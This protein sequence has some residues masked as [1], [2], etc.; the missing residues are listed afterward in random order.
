MFTHLHVHTEYSLLDGLCRIAPLVERA[1]EMGMRSLAITDHGSLYG[2]V[3]FYLQARER[4]VKPIIGSEFYVAGGSRFSRTAADKEPYHLVLLAKNKTGYQN[5]LKLSSKSHI[6]G[7]YYKPRVDRELLM[8]HSSG[9]VALSGCLRGEIARLVADGREKEARKSAEW[10]GDLFGADYYLEIQRHPIP[11]MERINNGLL[12][13]SRELNLPLV[14][15]NDVHYIDRQDARWQDLLLCI[16]T[17]SSVKDERRLKMSADSF[18]L[19][20]PEEMAELFNDV[21]EALSNTERIAQ[22]CNLELEFGQLHLPEVELPADKTG[23]AYL[24]ELCRDGLT[25]RYGGA[26]PT[27]VRERLEYELEVVRQTSFAHY[28]LVVWDIVFF[29]RKR[30]ISCG[31][32]G[33]AA[34]SI[35]LYCL[36]VTDVDPLKHKL[37]FERFLNVERKEMP[38]IDLD[39]QDDRRDEIIS[40]VAQKYGHDRVAQIITFGT[41]GAKAALRDVGR[42]LGMPYSQVDQVA[43]LIPFGV[44]ITLQKALDETEEFR[45]IYGNDPIVHELVDSAM[46]LEGI[47]RHAS[48]HAAGVVISKEPL[49]EYVPLQQVSRGEAKGMAMTQFG[50]GDI[51]KVG[52]L[53][54][55]LLG[56]INLTTLCTARQLVEKTRGIQLDLS[57]LP[58]DDRKTFDLLSSG[59]THGVFQLDGAGMRRY[60]KELKPSNFSDLAAMVALYR[61]GPKDHIPAFIRAKHGLEPIHYPHPALAGI[62]EETYGVIVYQDQVLFIVQTFAGYSLGQADIVRKAMGK[63]IPDIMRKE[64]LRFMEGAKRKGFSEKVAEDV[65]NLIEPFAG[66]A[67]NKAHSVSYAMIAYQTAYLKANYPVEYMTALL[68]SASG[69]TD[70]VAT[71]VADCQR[72]GLKVLPPDVNLSD[73][74][75]GVENQEEPA[76]R[77]G[78]ADIKNIG[79]QAIAPIISAVKAGGPF[80][81]L[82]DFCRRC[83][84]RG[85]NKRVLESLVKAGAMDRLGGRAALLQCVDR[86]L[87]VSHREQDLREK[88]QSTMFD[89]FG[90][91]T[92]TPVAEIE[93]PK[94]ECTLRDK[95]TWEKELLGVYLSEHPFHEAARQLASSTT[96]LCGQIDSEMVGQTVTVAGVLVTPRVGQ[97]K[98]R[99]PFVTATLEDLVGT[100]DITCW[101]EVYERT[102][103]L[104]VEGNILMVQGRVKVRQDNVQVVCDQVREYKADEVGNQAPVPAN[105]PLRHGKLKV[106]LVETENPDEDIARLRRAIDVLRSFPGDDQVLLNICSGTSKVSVEMTGV[107]VS[108]CPE[109]RL[110]LT[111]ALG[112]DALRFEAD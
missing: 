4:E 63:K 95:L 99:K 13:V 31:V 40:Y 93:L 2:A 41:L 27:D 35:I 50:M 47:S 52:L 110:Q 14:A 100:V 34:A 108:Y 24:T 44:G 97:T 18:Y 66:Y 37:V 60:L 32:R 73:V 71:A 36:G 21:P 88:G 39:F 53:K 5:L 69:Q 29:S 17:N 107:G 20:S 55:D 28:F 49:M 8:Q 57:H 83:D 94:V 58:L 56:L 70:K 51:A 81:S 43:R 89:L 7:F 98:N 102:E 74:N 12:A 61:P 3:E 109:L 87:W 54:L 103:E 33:S 112:R 30:N 72:M 106:I 65:F 19:K 92:D 96:A 111:G 23:D 6:E 45:R 62:L 10:Y 26:P 75:F 16:Q 85:M 9:L 22:D 105:P 64:R 104:W 84:L 78:L 79:P 48:T 80:K 101:S 68:V 1:R 77:F 91:S 46:K 38:D 90:Q 11:E 82:T 42:A 67:F 25:Q 15:T 59:E 76:I 86:I